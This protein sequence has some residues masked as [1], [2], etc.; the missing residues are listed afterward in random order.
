LIDHENGDRYLAGIVNLKIKPEYRS[1]CKEDAIGI[2]ELLEVFESLGFRS[3]SKK[4][5][6]SQPPESDFNEK[7]LKMADISLI[8]KLEVSDDTNVLEAAERL[9][10]LSYIAYAEPQFVAYDQYVP[11]DANLN[12]IMPYHFATTSTYEAWDITL[13]D[14]NVVIGITET[15]FD[16]NH[17]ELSGNIRYNYDDPNGNGDDDNDSY[18]DNFAGWDMVD[19]DNT[20][21]I[22]NEI[23]GTAVA[24]IA[25]A[26]ADNGIG[27]AGIGFK[28]KFLPVKVANN[29]Q[30]ITHGYEG[31]QY[32]VEQGCS[33]VNCSWGNTSFSQVAQDVVTWAAV[34]NDVV[35]IA[36]AGNN[37]ATTMYYPASYNYVLSV[38]GV[39]ANDV[40]DDGSNPPFTRNDSVDVSAPGYNVYTTATFNGSYLYSPPQGGTSMAGPIV[41]GIAGLVRSEFPCLT[42]LEV[43]E[44]IRSSA[45]NVDNL[46]ENIPYAGLI[47]TGRVNAEMAVSGTPCDPLSISEGDQNVSLDIYPNPSNGDINIRMGQPSAWA[48]EVL[49]SKGRVVLTRQVSTDR[50][51]VS[52][53]TPG[54]YLA[55]VSDDN[56][57]MTK[58]F[59]IIAQ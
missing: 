11:N 21:F 20:L 3:V 52:G 35:L 57:V 43:I 36:S 44:R 8:Y 5:R 54:Y 25:S 18:I 34:N 9:S 41:A 26:S 7:G 33:V 47:G 45:D 13:G 14:T 38:T 37:N 49:D 46:S 15:S 50:F 39:N 48:V 24:A 30:V 4:F 12:S 59:S 42:A 29:S 19:N 27:Y 55:R 22:N 10:R 31:I 23:H 51:V 1:L 53:L 32:C 16:V 58:P 6:G 56:R 28:C 2:P 17:P 40:F